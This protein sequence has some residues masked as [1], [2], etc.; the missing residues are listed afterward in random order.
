M[1]ETNFIFISYGCLLGIICDINVGR[2]LLVGLRGV[3]AACTRGSLAHMLG[4][5][6]VKTG[7]ALPA[8]GDVVYA[9]VKQLAVLRMRQKTVLAHAGAWQLARSHLK[10]TP[11]NVVVI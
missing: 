11:W 1:T 3:S 10:A 9:V 6:E 8:K 7:G 5:A 4:G 2:L